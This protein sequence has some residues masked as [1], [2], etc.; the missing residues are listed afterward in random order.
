MN[1]EDKHEPHLDVYKDR[2]VLYTESGNKQIFYEGK[3]S[4]YTK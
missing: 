4:D 3:P 2:S 1:Q